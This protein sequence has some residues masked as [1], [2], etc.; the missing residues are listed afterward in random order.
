MEKLIIFG[1]TGQDGSLLCDKLHSNF[2]IICPVRLGSSSINKQYLSHLRGKVSYVEIDYNTESIKKII[3]ETNPTYI[4]NFAGVSNVLDTW[5]DTN[6]ILDANLGI[7]VSIL[8]ALISMKSQAKFIQASSSLVFGNSN[9]ELCDEN[10]VR[11]PIFPYGITKNAADL[12]IQEAR[13]LFG[14]NACS[15][16]LFNHESER[17]APYFFTRKVVLAARSIAN[18]SVNEKLSLGDINTQKDMGFARDY[19]DAISKILEEKDAQDYVL[20][21]SV[22]THIREFL[23]EAFS[24]YGLNYREHVI[25]NADV[26]TQLYITPKR[27]NIDKAK[28]RLG[29]SPRVFSA[30]CLI[31]EETRRLIQ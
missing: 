23:S 20:G 15:V 7:P 1:G 25:T 3:K 11:N 22:L 29:W 5:K 24:Y 9:D 26:T 31:E 2:E 12:L 21:T 27:A 16:I 10:T 19:I 30:S 17:R 8:D 6:T 14:V 28:T 13:N 18:K 4:C